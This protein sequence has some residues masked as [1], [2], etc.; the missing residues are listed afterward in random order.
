VSAASPVGPVTGADIAAAEA[1]M[2]AMGQ[3]RIFCLRPGDE[4]LDAQLAERG[5][6]IL[7]PV[8]IYVC[9]VTR[10]TDLPVPRV[11]VFAIW[12]PLAI[13]REIWAQGGIG[14]ERV[15]VMERAEGPKT[16]LLL[17]QNDHPAG[18]GFVAMQTGIAMV[19]ALEILPDHRRRG[20]G[21]WA[22]RAAAHWALDNGADRLSVM[23]TK[24]NT[25]ANALYRSLGMEHAGEYHYR[26][27]ARGR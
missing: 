20:L 18:A 5:Y 14:P 13:M 16:G 12:E 23:C 25:G 2:L 26:H 21:Q 10:L 15:A 27:L 22:M 24:A 7:D 9:P 4:A 1:A 8:N 19:H 6:D 17:R 11:T 3:R